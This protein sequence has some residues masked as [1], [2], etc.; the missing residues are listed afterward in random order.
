MLEDIEE[1]FG[2]EI[3]SKSREYKI[4]IRVL[5]DNLT[6][7]AGIFSWNDCIGIQSLT[8]QRLTCTVLENRDIA[9]FY[10]NIIFELIWQQARPLK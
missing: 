6:W 4:Q 3:V 10:R 2:R 7:R 8:E 9:D 5:P 1:K